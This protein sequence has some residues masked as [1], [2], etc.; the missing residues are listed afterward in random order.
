MWYVEIL[1]KFSNLIL[2]I[3]NIKNIEHQY[4][5]KINLLKYISKIKNNFYLYNCLQIYKK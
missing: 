3:V 1:Q 5:I 4:I 2:T